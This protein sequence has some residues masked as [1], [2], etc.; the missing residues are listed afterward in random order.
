MPDIIR[1]PETQKLVLSVNDKPTMEQSLFQWL[2][3][4]GVAL[5]RARSTAKAMELL[6]RAHYDAV[7][8]NLRRMEYGRKHNTAGIDLTQQIRRINP[9]L[10]IFIYTM[11]IDLATHQSALSSGATLITANAMELQVALKQHGF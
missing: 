3:D 1:I 10:P 11:N 4:R 8:T 9:H 6:G 5:V 7:I 2:H